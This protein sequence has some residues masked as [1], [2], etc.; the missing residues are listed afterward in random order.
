MGIPLETFLPA[1]V[2]ITEPQPGNGF[3]VVYESKILLVTV[4][5]LLVI[6]DVPATEITF[7]HR[8]QTCRLSGFTLSYSPNPDLAFIVLEDAM[9]DKQ[10]NL[11]DSGLPWEWFASGKPTVPCPCSLYTMGFPFF[12]VLTYR[13]L[14]TASMVMAKLELPNYSWGFGTASFLIDGAE[15]YY[16]SPV[17]DTQHIKIPMFSANGNTPII[18]GLVAANVQALGSGSCG[19]VIH[20]TVVREFIKNEMEKYEKRL[21]SRSRKGLN[22]KIYCFWKLTK[23]IFFSLAGHS[24]EPVPEGSSSEAK[25]EKGKEKTS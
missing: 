3:F 11:S 24:Y 6:N 4:A 14:H 2:A 5:H 23:S 18:Y 21:K 22:S 8:Q 16:G 17:F 13:T 20:G 10:L 9:Q 25:L 7:V 19:I 15:G 12:Q 1:A